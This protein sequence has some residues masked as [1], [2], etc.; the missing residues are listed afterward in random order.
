MK[1]K[2]I[3]IKPTLL[4]F[5]LLAIPST[6][7][8]SSAGHPWLMFNSPAPQNKFIDRESKIIRRAL[9]KK[10][11][12]RISLS[13]GSQ[14]TFSFDIPEQYLK[15][16]NVF[17][18]VT[19]VVSSEHPQKKLFTLSNGK[20]RSPSAPIPTPAKRRSLSAVL[21]TK[22]SESR[23]EVSFSPCAPL[24][25]E[26]LYYVISYDPRYQSRVNKKSLRKFMGEDV[27]ENH[28]SEKLH[29]NKVPS[30]HRLVFVG[31]STVAGIGS[32]QGAT[33]SHILQQKLDA[34]RPEEFEVLNAGIG[35][36]TYVGHIV[37]IESYYPLR[38]NTWPS[39]TGVARY[40]HSQPALSEINADTLVLA[41]HW[42]DIFDFKDFLAYG[43]DKRSGQLYADIA[44]TAFFEFIKY[45]SQDNFEAAQAAYDNML[46][47]KKELPISKELA[48]E[49]YRFL[50][51][52][53]VE[54]WMEKNPNSKLVLMTLPNKAP[55]G[56]AF[57][58]DIQQEVY[59]EIA[60][61]YNI[62]LLDYRKA[63]EESFPAKSRM[64]RY[65]ETHMF[66][67]AIHFSPIGNQWLA[68]SIYQELEKLR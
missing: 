22:L 10:G 9:V 64:R 17:V 50:T 35:A 16:E 55:Y 43:R 31:N 57:E 66:T 52:T 20:L 38:Q 14:K 47:Q 59:R 40:I 61:E 45:P 27:A 28:Y 26:E 41:V 32:R 42:N 33:I 53:F 63:F 54:R 46:A 19:A 37:S 24:S 48:K 51:R 21:Q 7:S 68:D 36:A 11:D 5:A 30:S 23:V 15:N 65:A 2:P 13:K 6:I 62:A 25:I 60:D 39:A 34:L 56:L 18:S 29:F 1:K 67:D 8:C 3:A 44:L 49:H 4:A 58:P 12:Q